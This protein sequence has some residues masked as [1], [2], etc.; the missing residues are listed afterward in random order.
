MFYSRNKKNNVYPADPIFFYIKVGLKGQNYIDTC[1]WCVE[2][3]VPLKPLLG[4]RGTVYAA[5]QT[6]M[7]LYGASMKPKLRFSF[8]FY[9]SLFPRTI[10]K[11]FFL[12]INR[13]PLKP[14]LGGMQAI[15]HCSRE[16]RK[17]VIGKQCRP[18][19]D[20]AERGVWSGSPLF[21]NS[22]TIFL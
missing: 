7:L 5:M 12:L 13:V 10:F 11:D 21:A 19:S 6:T 18:R 16:T 14:M 2:N 9:R 4:V 20:A 17:R 22:L 15:T 1:S 8:C 3:Q